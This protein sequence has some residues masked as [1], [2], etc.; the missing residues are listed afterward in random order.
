M[1]FSSSSP[2]RSARIAESPPVTSL[3]SIPSSRALLL[4]FYDEDIPPTCDLTGLDK[5]GMY[6]RAASTS[7]RRITD[8]FVHQKLIKDELFM[9][10]DGAQS[11]SWTD[12]TIS[13]RSSCLTLCRDKEYI[14][15]PYSPPRFSRQF[16]FC[17]DVPG[18][19]A[20]EASPL[21]LPDVVRLWQS[22]T[23][24][25]TKAELRIPIVLA[26]ALLQSDTRSG[27]QSMQVTLSREILSQP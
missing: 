8:S 27:G 19:L 24:L 20:E 4:R 3:R 1:M 26:K 5:H 2:L 25:G 14:V 10:D 16:N 15:E 18:K 6:Y 21:N 23:K 17:Q 13:L 7:L 12:Y 11:Q 22:C 9:V